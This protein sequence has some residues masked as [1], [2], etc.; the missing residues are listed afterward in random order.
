MTTTTGE[1]TFSTTGR[2]VA[3]SKF[4]LIPPGSYT[5]KLLGDI[6]VAK[7]DRP[8]AV[9][10][11]NLACEVEGTATTEG[12]KNQRVFHRL[13]LMLKPGKDGVVNMDRANGLTAMAQAM[14]TEVEGVEIIEREATTADGAAV[15]LEYLNP[16]Q[17][18]E[19]LKSFVGTTMSVRIKTEKGTAG[20]SDKSV[21][22]KF[23]TPAT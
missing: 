11:V 10:Y 15:K 8:D 5:A 18:V 9:P 21:L 2:S 4:P 20:Y 7:A 16:A 3:T 14:G 17:V 12:G 1:R 13:F 19:W 23:L 22:D 6:S